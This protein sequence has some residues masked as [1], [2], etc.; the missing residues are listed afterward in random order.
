LYKDLGPPSRSKAPLASDLLL[1]LLLRLKSAGGCAWALCIRQAPII[2]VPGI[3]GDKPAHLGTHILNGLGRGLTL[4]GRILPR[5][6]SDIQS[7]RDL[8]YVVSNPAK[9]ITN[10]AQ[11]LRLARIP[12]RPTTQVND[13]ERP[14][15][16]GR[17]RAANFSR[18]E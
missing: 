1:P 17:C 12:L 6:R 7:P 9:L 5:M 16:V 8:V 13:G 2:E 14:E 4:V 18:P 3:D 11:G 10:A 15:P